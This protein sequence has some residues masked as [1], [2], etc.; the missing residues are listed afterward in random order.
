M[1]KVHMQ[2]FIQQKLND[3]NLNIAPLVQREANLELIKLSKQC[4][5]HKLEKQQSNKIAVDLVKNLK[6][7][8]KTTKDKFDALLRYSI[9]GNVMDYGAFNNFDIK[10][11]IDKALKMKLAIDQSDKLYEKIQNAKLILYLG[12][13]AGEIVFDKLFIQNCMTKKVVYA[14][15]NAPILNDVTMSD[16]LQ[17]GIDNVAKVI[18]NG[19]DAPSTILEKSSQEF[20]NYYKN[21]DLI[22]SKGQG[23]LEG[24]INQKDERLFFLLM[25]KCQIIADKLKVDKNSFVVIN[26]NYDK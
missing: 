2:N 13:N 11:N 23:N 20:L 8:F 16:A 10:E 6:T 5:L 14:V 12:D 25:I 7:N 19:F 15:K 1:D 3:P 9:A 22:I 24:L 18:T 26:S 21:A 4:D 17:V